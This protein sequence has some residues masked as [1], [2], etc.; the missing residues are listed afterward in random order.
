VLSDDQKRQIYDTYG[1]A[2]LKN[3]MGGGA[4]GFSNPFD[5][6]EQFFS[7]GTPTPYM[8][9]CSALASPCCPSVYRF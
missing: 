8:H 2:G 9:M 7:G 5:I 4:A 3:N 6:F 1:E